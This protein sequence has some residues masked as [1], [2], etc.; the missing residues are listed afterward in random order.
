MDKDKYLPWRGMK[1]GNND[2]GVPV[3]I[4]INYLIFLL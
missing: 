1:V 3:L 4:N 2:I